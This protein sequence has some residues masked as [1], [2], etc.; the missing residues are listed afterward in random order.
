M[1]D[2]Y[3]HVRFDDLDLVHDF[4]NVSNSRPSCF[5]SFGLLAQ[6]HGD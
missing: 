5:D 3:A 2:I 6:L 1:H 4:E